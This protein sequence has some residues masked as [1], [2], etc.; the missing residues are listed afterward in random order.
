MMKPIKRPNFLTM[1]AIRC[2][3][4]MAIAATRRRGVANDVHQ[5]AVTPTPWGIDGLDPVWIAWSPYPEQS[6][7]I[8]RE[9]V[10]QAGNAAKIGRLVGKLRMEIERRPEARVMTHDNML[11]RATQLVQSVEEPLRKMQEEGKLADFNAGYLA[12]KRKAEADEAATVMTFIAWR[13]QLIGELISAQV[14]RMRSAN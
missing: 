5:V 1:H 10:R 4:M 13:R 2:I 9:A 7:A 14:A 11:K 8:A 12:Y 3:D 6:R